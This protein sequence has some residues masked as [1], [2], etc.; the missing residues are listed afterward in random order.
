[1]HFLANSGSP[2]RIG[3]IALAFLTHFVR[4]FV[5]LLVR[6]SQVEGNQEGLLYVPVGINKKLEV[7][8]LG[9]VCVDAPGNAVI[10]GENAFSAI[11]EQLG[12]D[13]AK[14]VKRVQL[15]GNLIDAGPE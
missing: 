2:L 12:M 1:R 13:V 7:V 5:N 11:F 6:L 14:V 8:S 10:C 15:E 4:D 9:V 3:L